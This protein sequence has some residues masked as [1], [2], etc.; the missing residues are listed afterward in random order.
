MGCYIAAKHGPPL[1][2]DDEWLIEV[3]SGGST[4]EISAVVRSESCLE[5]DVHF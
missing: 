1:S 3:R 5:Q 4:K 2:Y